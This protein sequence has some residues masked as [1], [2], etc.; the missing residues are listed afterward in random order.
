MENKKS[1]SKEIVK[2]LLINKLARGTSE[3][4]IRESLKEEGLEPNEVF[5]GYS[6]KV[7]QLLK[8]AR[9]MTLAEK[10]DMSWH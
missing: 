4:I 5:K 6:T 9:V 1:N 3:E 7:D 2:R 8:Q 10:E